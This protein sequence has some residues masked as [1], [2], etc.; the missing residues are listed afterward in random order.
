MQI[1]LFETTTE[2]HDLG[3]YRKEWSGIL[4]PLYDD[5]FIKKHIHKQFLEDSSHYI[6]KYQN[7]DYWKALLISSQQFYHFEANEELKILDIGSGSG[8][9]IFPIM[10]LYPNAHIVASDLSINL[11]QSLKV[12]FEKHYKNRSLYIV[13][14]D[15]EDIIFENNS[16]DIVVGGA[17]LHH[18]FDPRKTVEQCYNVLRPNG[19]AIFFEPFEIGNQILAIILK[20][21]IELNENKA[22][23]IHQILKKFVPSAAMLD[24][25][26]IKFFKALCHDFAVRK[27][28]DKQAA[29]FLHMDDKWLFTKDFINNMAKQ[30]GF[31][32]TTIYPLH[33][34][35]DMFYN[36]ASAY[37]RLGLNKDINTLPQWA[38]K[39]IREIDEHFSKE[40]C[41]ELLI[42][43]GIILKK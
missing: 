15:A 24:H 7:L 5:N 12:Y 11:L 34:P 32:Q 22:S 28:V 2:L 30:I 17:I 33:S 31:R 10:D 37:L 43:G 25:N 21:I 19:V 4:S 39:K 35:K 9:T 42:E 8:N 3:K 16:I 14:L 1:G 40:L 27:G 13:Q 38:I 18:L 26:T 29:H 23:P 6:E 41:H 36:Q 20:Q